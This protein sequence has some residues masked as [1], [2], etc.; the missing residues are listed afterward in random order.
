MFLEKIFFI[1]AKILI[2]VAISLIKLKLIF[3]QLK[4]FI[5]YLNSSKLFLKTL[6]FEILDLRFNYKTINNNSTIKLTYFE[7]SFKKISI[8]ISLKESVVKIKMRNSET[9]R[10]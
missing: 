1:C 10:L 8:P 4:N 7:M 2:F 5:A 9:L 6:N 3:F